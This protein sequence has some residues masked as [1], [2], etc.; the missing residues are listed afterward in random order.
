MIS[1]ISS[2]GMST[3][4]RIVKPGV[5]IFMLSMKYYLDMIIT[6]MIITNNLVTP[7]FFLNK[8]RSKYIE[9]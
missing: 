5:S 7:A 8:R 9:V 4:L 6:S 3:V 1:R 2:W